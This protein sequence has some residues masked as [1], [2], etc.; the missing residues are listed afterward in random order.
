[1]SFTK[2]KQINLNAR[3]GGLGTDSLKTNN[4]GA[5]NE[6]LNLS[7]KTDRNEKGVFAKGLGKPVLGLGTHFFGLNPASIMSPT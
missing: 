5:F 7:Y 6:T 4:V 3:L 1:M 2:Q